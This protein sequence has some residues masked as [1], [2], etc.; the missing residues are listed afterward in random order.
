MGST[1]TDNRL[2]RLIKTIFATEEGEI[3]C[4]DCFEQVDQY[5]DLL[6]TGQDPAT[7]LPQVRQHLDQCRCCHEELEVLIAIL[8]SETD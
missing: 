1:S 3:A 8:E 7:V 6:R 2:A 4:S 5:V